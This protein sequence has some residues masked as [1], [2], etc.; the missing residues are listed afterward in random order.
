VKFIKEHIYE[1]FEEKSDPIHDLNI[2]IIPEKIK[3]WIDNHTNY[4]RYELE[5]YPASCAFYGKL[6]FLKFLN[7][8]K[9]TNINSHD[10][11]ALQIALIDYKG[12]IK[13][14]QKMIDYLVKNSAFISQK[15]LTAFKGSN[16][17]PLLQKY[18][19]K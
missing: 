10:S 16:K 2:G 18:A 12:D 6:D 9:I 8:E 11:L 3:D 13:N 4:S 14:K 5:Y 19:K 15:I 7:D 17:L 1:K